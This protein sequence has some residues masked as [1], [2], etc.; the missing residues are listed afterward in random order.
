MIPIKKLM[1]KYTIVIFILLIFLSSCKKEEKANSVPENNLKAVSDKITD[2]KGYELMKQKCFICHFETPDPSKMEQMIAPPIQRVQE[3]YK[4]SFPNKEDFVKAVMAYVNNP[5]EEKTL[6]PGAVKKFNLMPKVV[7]DQQE[8]KAIV[9]TLYAFNFESSPKM[10]QKMTGSLHLNKGKKWKIKPET[11]DR[12]NAVK[13]KL[14]TFNSDNL[15]DY[16]QLGK[17][18]FND[19]KFILLDKDYEGA[20][21]DQ[22][23]NFFGGIEGHIHA[24]IATNSVEVAQKQ[25][26][27]LK[28]EFNNFNQYFEK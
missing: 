11:F 18:V 27:I 6:M 2:T 17:E 1:K 12:I 28:N 4:P 15:S 5:S 14:D 22:L 8:L 19:A 21:F 16:N 9:E 13:K 23:H 25:V 10:H 20:V 26:V 3:H 7:Y 24:L